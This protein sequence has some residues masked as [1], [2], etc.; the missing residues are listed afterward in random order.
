MMAALDLALL[1][2]LRLSPC[3]LLSD[4]ISNRI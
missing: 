3:L 1:Q 4:W 2:A